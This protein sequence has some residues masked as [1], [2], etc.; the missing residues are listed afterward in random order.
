MRNNWIVSH[1]N[2]PCGAR[3]YTFI[4]HACNVKSSSWL[5]R[6]RFD[7]RAAAHQF[8]KR[9]RHIEQ[10]PVINHVLVI[11]LQRRFGTFLREQ[12]SRHRRQGYAYARKDPI[13][14]RARRPLQYAAGLRGV[15]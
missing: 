10:Q 4:G 8:V 11:L 6:A 5:V 13:A 9:V 15:G 1:T 3:Q 12:A 2:S 14:D 7:L